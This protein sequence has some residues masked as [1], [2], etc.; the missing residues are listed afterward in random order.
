MD[1][2]QVTLV[3]G[4]EWEGAYINGRLVMEG[5][6]L[7]WPYFLKRHVVG[8]RLT[9]VESR[10]ADTDWLDDVGNLPEQLEDV[11]YPGSGA[12]GTL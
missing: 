9:S 10:A 12:T 1:D 4:D 11:V 8:A 3:Y 2:V 5:H 6:S 7:N